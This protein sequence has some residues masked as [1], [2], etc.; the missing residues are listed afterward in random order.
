[1]RTP[2]GGKAAA[3]RTGHARRTRHAGFA[4]VAS[5]AA[6]GLGSAAGCTNA[7]QP[8]ATARVSAP[9]S[10]VP[11]AAASRPR[12]APA[13]APRQRAI[14]DAAAI[15]ASF[16]VPPGA[17][18]LPGAPAANGGALRQPLLVAAAANLV[19]QVAWWQVPGQPRQVL[20]WERAHLPRRF[21]FFNETTTDGGPA[22]RPMWADELSLP[23]VPAVLDSRIL[24]VEVADAGGGQTAIRVDAQVTWRQPRPASERVPSAARVVT[25]TALPGL[26]P[27]GRPPAPVTITDVAVVRRIAALTDSLPLQAPGARKCLGRTA[28]GIL[29]TFR[30]RPGG[31]ALA[32]AGTAGA[33]GS[34]LFTIDGRRQPA[35]EGGAEL[36]RQLLSVAR[37]HWPGY[38]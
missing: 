8:P 30:A 12:A 24:L 14:A 35:L 18:R 33:C 23:P 34:V 29:L 32:T 5:L 16:A 3:G 6:I 10:P 28:G 15:L 2:P 9:A 25:I 31:P 27:G 22:L 13:P 17:R 20:G 36:D 26:V 7:P 21:A 1:M 4:A 38:G 11:P 19:D 37:L